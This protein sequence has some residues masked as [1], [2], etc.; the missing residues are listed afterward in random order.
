MHYQNAKA[1][2]KDQVYLIQ[3]E[4]DFKIPQHVIKNTWIFYANHLAFCCLMRDA[5]IVIGELIISAK[6]KLRD[7]T[8]SKNN[9]TS[10]PI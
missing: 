8:S 4:L 5:K 9:L 2:F 7:M 10:I 3:T 1:S 6:R